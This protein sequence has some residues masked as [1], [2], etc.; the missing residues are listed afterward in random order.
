MVPPRTSKLIVEIILQVVNKP[1]VKPYYLLLNLEVK[2]RVIAP[3]V[4]VK[5]TKIRPK[6]Q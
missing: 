1:T 2:S 5:T 6:Y 3:K 4:K